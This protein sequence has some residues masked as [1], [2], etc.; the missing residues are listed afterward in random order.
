M[1]FY[2]IENAKM[3]KSYR[4]HY[5]LTSLAVV[6]RT[7]LTMTD[8]WVQVPVLQR[9]RL[10]YSYNMQEGRQFIKTTDDKRYIET[11]ITTELGMRRNRSLNLKQSMLILCK[12][13]NMQ[14]IHFTIIMC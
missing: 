13:Y 3:L 11:Q 9:S 7:C 6:K 14:F 1:H 8:M 5:L 10:E 2:Y 4:A 12:N